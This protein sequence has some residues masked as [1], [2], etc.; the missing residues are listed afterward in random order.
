ME[1]SAG[2]SA[3]SVTWQPQQNSPFKVGSQTACNAPL[4][5]FTLHNDGNGTFSLDN[6]SFDTTAN[7][8]TV[9]RIS[10]GQGFMFGWSQYY[11]GTISIKTATTQVDMNINNGYY[12]TI[13]VVEAQ[14][15][16]VLDPVT[17]VDANRQQNAWVMNVRDDA[18]SLE[19]AMGNLAPVLSNTT[20]AA[21]LNALSGNLPDNYD[22]RAY[23]STTITACDI[24]RTAGFHLAAQSS[25]TG[26]GVTPFSRSQ[27][28]GT[29]P[30]MLGYTTI[31]NIDHGITGLYYH[32]TMHQWGAFL[33]TSLGVSDGAHWVNNSSVAGAL[34]GCSFAQ[35][36][37]G[38]F[39]TAAFPLTDGD[40]ELYVAGLLPASQVGP[41]YV[42]S[43]KVQNCNAG[44]T[45]TGP[46]KTVT[47]NDVIAIHGPRVPA[48]DGKVKTYKHAI[49]VTS[50]N[51][52]LTPIEMTYFGR[53]AQLW[54]GSTVETGA[55]PPYQWP[56][57][58][59]GA[60]AF[61]MLLDSW[62]GPTIRANAIANAAGNFSGA[63]A[64]GEIITIYGSSLGPPSLAGLTINASNKVDTTAG[65]TRV[66]FDGIPS[67]M[68]FSTSGVVSAIVPYEVD[69]RTAVSVQVEY[70]GRQS[71]VVSIPVAAAAPAIFTQDTS[72]KGA[73]SIVH[74]DGS[75]NTNSNRAAAGSIVLIFGTGEGQSTSGGVTGSITPDIQS[76]KL[77]PSVT[78][79]GIPAKIQFAGPAPGEIAGLFQVNAFI[80]DGLTSGPQPIEIKFGSFATQPGVLIYVK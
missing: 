3:T 52:L 26:I 44:Q 25:D 40:L 35:Q 14:M 74:L 5:T 12:V 34:G 20:T 28:Y 33:N 73:G 75:I 38:T 10:T 72:G 39:K 30:K 68:V 51:R 8:R 13:P 56:K 67:P 48:F 23:V 55:L 42:A 36:P 45:L 79:G 22:F 16:K 1:V 17:P 71:P 76:T 57:Y 37:D 15:F 65:G 80:P 50:Q 43:G 6:I 41:T 4:Q 21:T 54:E 9:G 32:E 77:T 29:G 49:T 78:I 47:V 31:A 24:G 62:T 69:G 64:P 27:T 59:R 19:R 61:N 63:I 7:C 60:S 58:T 46:I 11:T 66:L 70:Q 18:F 2:A 53:I